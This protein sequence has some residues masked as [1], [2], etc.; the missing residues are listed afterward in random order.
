MVLTLKKKEKK[1]IVIVTVN[2]KTEGPL[3]LV[4]VDIHS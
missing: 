4:I 1:I 3:N 2:M